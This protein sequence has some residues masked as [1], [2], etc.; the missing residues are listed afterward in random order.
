MERK[1]RWENARIGDWKPNH[2]NQVILEHYDQHNV[3]HLVC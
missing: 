2:L 1:Q 3:H